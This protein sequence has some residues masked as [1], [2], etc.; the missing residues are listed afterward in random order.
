M[1]LKL[2]SKS[3]DYATLEWED[4][5]YADFQQTIG[6]PRVYWSGEHDY[7]KSIALELLEP[8]LLDLFAYCGG[9][10]SLK[11]TLLIADQLLPRLQDLHGKDYVHRDVK[12]NNFLVG[13]G[14]KGSTLHI[15]DF[16]LVDYV[17]DP[18]NPHDPYLDLFVVG[19]PRFAS[20][21]GHEG[22]GE[23]TL[24]AYL[25]CPSR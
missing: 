16:G 6:F 5:V 4:N 15:C 23:L 22:R 13:T 18:A 10:F 24:S 1:A 12:P 20:I 11:T 9:K 14:P 17:E 21:S 8:T 25:S 19:N 2:E 3:S 7:F